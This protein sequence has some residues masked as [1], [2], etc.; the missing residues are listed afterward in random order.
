[1]SVQV[2]R[3]MPEATTLKCQAW[4]PLALFWETRKVEDCTL[5]PEEGAHLA[6]TFTFD[7]QLLSRTEK[8][9]SVVSL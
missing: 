3:L 4:I 6:G 7:F 8:S 2:E 5:P 9:M 1:M